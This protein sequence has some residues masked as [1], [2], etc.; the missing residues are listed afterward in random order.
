[1]R[2]A[3]LVATLLV[4]AN[5]ASLTPAQ[6]AEVMNGLVGEAFH[7]EKLDGYKACYLDDNVK[8]F[9]TIE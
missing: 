6:T 8:N 4:G 5:A 9:A 7:Y 3:P 1:M 2:T